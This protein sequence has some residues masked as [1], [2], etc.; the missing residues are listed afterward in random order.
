MHILP[1]DKIF[2]L[3]REVSRRNKEEKEGD[4]N[5][6]SSSYVPLCPDPYCSCPCHSKNGGPPPIGRILWRMLHT[7]WNVG[8]L[9]GR[10]NV[11]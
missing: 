10:A 11:I 8:A 5:N 3:E 4:N 9:L 6:G 2:N 1:T 7:I